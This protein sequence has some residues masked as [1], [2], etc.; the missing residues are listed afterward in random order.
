MKEDLIRTILISMSN[1]L[2]QDQIDEL[3]MQL[4]I[5]LN[6]YEIVEKQYEI[7]PYSNSDFGLLRKF[8]EAKVA[9]GKSRNTVKIYESNIKNMILA[10]GKQIRDIDSDDIQNYLYRYQIERKVSKVTIRNLRANFNSFFAWLRR[11]GKITSN[12]MDLIEYIKL[13]EIIKSPFTDEQL[14]KLKDN[15]TNI[16]DLALIDFLNSTM[17]RVGEVY[18]LNKTDID[19]NEREC[20]V[21]GK[22]N[23]E[24]VVFFDGDAKIHLQQYLNSRKD[25]NPALFV[26]NNKKAERI[27]INGI[28]SI[29]K[30][31]GKMSCVEKVHPHR[32]RRTGATRSLEK[33]MPLEQIKELLGH[34]RI[35]TTLI[36]AK[37]NH[38]IIKMT[39]QRITS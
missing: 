25:N 16:R 20:I 12:P 21:L 11:N 35:D 31:I 24:R 8:L 15:C 39:Y 9:S 32:F 13:D 26:W 19:F 22:G 34:S 14:I 28:Q 4:H 30:R 5:K 10:L 33:G 23:K 27:S 29:L 1:C 18:K 37:T 17:V 2:T 6:N 36:Y 3:K 7:M 38:K